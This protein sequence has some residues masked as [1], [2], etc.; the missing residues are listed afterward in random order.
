M[1]L[2]TLSAVAALALTTGLQANSVETAV[3]KVK[4][5]ASSVEFNG[6][7][8]FWYQ[9]MDHEGMA[10]GKKDKGLFQRDS[11]QFNEWGNVEAQFSVSG[12]INEHLKAKGTFM[13]VST[14][15]MDSHLTSFETSRPGQTGASNSTMPQPFW[16]HE[17]YLDYVFTKNT[18]LKVGRMELDTPLIYTENW[19]ATANSFE[20][21][22]AV[23]TDLPKTT[24]TA[25]WIA[26]GNGATDNLMFAP[27][28]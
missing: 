20:A 24:L 27:Q 17:A 15:G 21:L 6:Q 28:V 12:D 19:N 7:L 16:V 26:K 2:V 10:N 14:M 18:D 3:D 4:D 11:N 23:N 9:T 8:K 5:V 13:T 1:K 25:A 22:T